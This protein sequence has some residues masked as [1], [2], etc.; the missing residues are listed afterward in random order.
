MPPYSLSLFF[1]S[2]P[3][4]TKCHDSCHAHLHVIP[5]VVPVR[6]DRPVD[7]HSS[8]IQCPRASSVRSHRRI[9]V[10]C[11]LITDAQ[12][13][14]LSQMSSMYP[15]AFFSR[16]MGPERLSRALAS[17][18]PPRLYPLTFSRHRASLRPAIRLP[19]FRRTLF[20]HAAVVFHA[21]P[22]I[23]RSPSLMFACSPLHGATLFSLIIYHCFVISPLAL[24]V[25]SH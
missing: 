4:S 23:M 17:N 19:S 22:R 1:A 9:F 24:R 11:L 3:L 13:A 18:R 10:R 16:P 15:V 5:S 20:L 25:S 8:F 2:Q 21:S 12:R 6:C 14:S 7:V